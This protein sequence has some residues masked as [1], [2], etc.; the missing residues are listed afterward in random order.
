MTNLI[1]QQQNEQ[2][3]N[4]IQMNSSLDSHH[5]HTYLFV[6]RLSSFINIFACS[7]VTIFKF[8]QWFC[9]NSIHNLRWC[10][11]YLP[12]LY[13]YPFAYTIFFVWLA[14]IFFA[15]I[16]TDEQSEMLISKAS[17][18]TQTALDDAAL[19]HYSHTLTHIRLYRYTQSNQFYYYYAIP[20]HFGCWSL[21]F[22]VASAI[23][24]NVFSIWNVK[25][26]EQNFSI[27]THSTRSKYIL[28]VYL[29]IIKYLDF[30]QQQWILDSVQR[31][32]VFF[33][34][35][36]GKEMDVFRIWQIEQFF[37]A[38]LQMS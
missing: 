13:A 14:I 3:K 19:K 22:F 10:L 7:F 6:W 37:C 11:T 1:E 24:V 31:C 16:K 23:V 26:E 32:T 35:K 15:H 18:Q 36:N 20:Y 2:K 9:R 5:T 34:S 29:S 8:S 27:Q 30:R 38:I 4:N 25:E 28:R 17:K 21:F 12:V 33:H